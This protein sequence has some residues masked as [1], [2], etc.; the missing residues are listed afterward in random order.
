V[1]PARVGSTASKTDVTGAFTPPESYNPVTFSPPNSQPVH[2]SSSSK[3]SFG[4]PVSGPTDG[5]A[6]ISETYLAVKA[7]VADSLPSGRLSVTQTTH[8]KDDDSANA[9]R[10]PLTSRLSSNPARLS[11][12]IDMMATHEWNLRSLDAV[13]VSANFLDNHIGDLMWIKTRLL[14]HQGHLLRCRDFAQRNLDAINR[15]LYI[16][17]KME[18]VRSSLTPNT[19]GEQ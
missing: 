12:S 15:A 4:I 16:D 2:Q 19:D 1:K 13:L 18:E 3:D 17:S 11:G 10:T 7:S 6:D 8:K 14:E 5:S 9:S